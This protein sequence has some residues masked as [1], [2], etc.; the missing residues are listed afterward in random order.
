MNT[1]RLHLVFDY[2]FGNV[3]FCGQV[4]KKN[5]FIGAESIQKLILLILLIEEQIE[6]FK[7]KHAFS[8]LK[9]W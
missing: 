9:I 3:V 6:K 1:N 8:L 2:T 4:L 7:N 5:P